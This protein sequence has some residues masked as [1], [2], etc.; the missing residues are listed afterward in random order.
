[1]PKFQMETAAEILKLGRL[2]FLISGFLLY[3][4]GAL[5]ALLSGAQ[6]SPDKYLLGYLILGAGHLSISYSNDYFDVDVD[7]HGT[8]SAFSGGSGVLLRKPQLRDTSRKIAVALIVFSILL[9]ALFIL[10]YRETPLFLMAVIFGN[11]LGWFYSAPPLML[12]YRGL[13]E[14]STT[15]GIGILVPGMG[16]YVMAGAVSGS[17]LLILPPL[18]FCAL[19]FILS[20]EVPDADSDRAGGKNTFVSKKGVEKGLYYAGLSILACV[21]YFIVLSLSGSALPV[22]IW[23]LAAA[24]LVPGACGLLSIAARHADKTAQARQ[25]ALNV[26]SF[27]AFV[28]LADIYFILALLR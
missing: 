13:G 16:F 22:P 18:V 20:V 24:S 25:V 6:F 26:S 17:F 10:I 3:T 2:R 9:G 23:P 27:I 11:L 8:P 28:S 7:R 21:A 12:S 4:M 1:M 15:L 14:V 5:F 19:A